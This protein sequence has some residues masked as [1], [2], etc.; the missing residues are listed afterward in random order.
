MLDTIRERLKAVHVLVIDQDAS[1]VDVLDWAEIRRRAEADTGGQSLTVI[2]LARALRAFAN[3]VGAND[4]T[5]TLNDIAVLASVEYARAY[6]WMGQGI[7]TPSIRVKSGRSRHTGPLFSYADA[8]VASVCASLRPGRGGTPL[9]I[10]RRA[11]EL[12]RFVLDIEPTSSCNLPA[13]SHHQ[14]C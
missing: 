13:G 8:F 3:R 6:N 11:A 5:F 7:L 10:V 14:P 2:D 4:R 9:P 1:T 12:L